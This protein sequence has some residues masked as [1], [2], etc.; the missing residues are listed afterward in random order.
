MKKIF[1]Y[2][3]AVLILPSCISQKVT[4]QAT[5]KIT[6]K[7]ALLAESPMWDYRSNSLLWIDIEG[8][9]LHKYSFDTKTEKTLSLGKRPGTVVLTEQ[10]DIQIA[11]LEDSLAYTCIR[12]NK[13]DKISGPDYK[14]QPVRFNDGKVDPLGHLWIG[15]VDCKDYSNPI[16]HLYKFEK[17][18]TFT[19]KKA[20]VTT[21]NGIS[22]SPDGTIMYYIDSPTRT[23]VAYDFDLKTGDIFNPRVVIHTPEDL[24]TPDGS[25]ID[26]EGMLWVA[27]WGGSCV[28]RW[29]PKNG[30]IL[31][32]IQ[33]PAKNVTAVAFGG[34]NLDILFITTAQIA[35]SPEDEKRYPDAGNIFTIKPGVKGIKANIFIE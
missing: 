5:E 6:T 35:M 27:Q 25:T 3:L 1:F 29:N 33:V 21:S 10:E 32:K 9:S 8:K 31:E 28:I 34:P 23:V 15:T 20:G 12:C 19:I 2:A 17:D 22:W 18:Q 14:G 16:A 4:M 30:K 13:I 26:A 7:P 11:A 24:G